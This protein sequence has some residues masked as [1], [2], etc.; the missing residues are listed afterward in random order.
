MPHAFVNDSHWPGV[1]VQCARYIAEQTT[2]RGYGTEQVGIDAGLAFQFDPPFPMHH[3]LLGA[4]KYGLASLGTL[5][6]LPERGAVL[7]AAPLRIEGGSG[8]P[9]RIY[10]LV[11]T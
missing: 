6:A 3:Y 4:G 5:E 10:A 1:T 2:L 7:I 8:S 11:H 9:S